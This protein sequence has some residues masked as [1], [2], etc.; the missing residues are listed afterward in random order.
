[1]SCHCCPCAGMATKHLASSTLPL[2]FPLQRYFP[3]F[4]PS[5]FTSR[6][7]ELMVK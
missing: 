7:Q 6:R 1:M 4:F 2:P 5:Q 3:G